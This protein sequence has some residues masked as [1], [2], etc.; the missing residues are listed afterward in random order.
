MP[1]HAAATR[2]SVVACREQPAG[3]SLQD[4]VARDQRHLVELQ[5]GVDVAVAVDVA[6]HVVPATAVERV[7]E[8][9]AGDGR[10]AVGD[11]IELLDVGSERLAGEH[12][13]D[14]VGAGVRRLHH[15]IAGRVDVVD[16]AA[17]TALHAL[18]AD[19]AVERIVAP[20]TQQDVVAVQP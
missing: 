9:V 18:V 8:R 10:A 6:Q 3:T 15:D 13:L 12:G 11:D 5:H 16:V 20:A 1:G 17:G 7:G 4:E 14:G 2:S 19:A